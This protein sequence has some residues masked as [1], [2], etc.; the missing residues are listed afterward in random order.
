MLPRLDRQ[1]L[2]ARGSAPAPAP[3]GE[4]V[5]LEKDEAETLNEEG[6]DPITFEPFSKKCDKDD[7]KDEVDPCEPAFRVWIADELGKK[8]RHSKVYLAR[9]MWQWVGVEEKRVDPITKQLFWRQDWMELRDKYNPDKKMP[10]WVFNLPVRE[11]PLPPYDKRYIPSEDGENVT[12]YRAKKGKRLLRRESTDGSNG[13]GTLRNY[14]EYEGAKGKEAIRRSAV[15]FDDGTLKSKQWWE[16]AK[17]KEYAVKREVYHSRDSYTIHYAAGTTLFE[18]RVVRKKWVSGREVRYEGEHGKERQVSKSARV[19][20]GTGYPN[21]HHRSKDLPGFHYTLDDTYERTYTGDQGSEAIVRI[22][23]ANRNGPRATM[24]FK[25]RK[26]AL[27]PL[28]ENSTLFMVKYESLGYDTAK[29]MYQT[30]DVAEYVG[31]YPNEALSR[32][33]RA[34]GFIELYSGPANKELNVFA[35]RKEV[36]DSSV[37][38]KD[39]PDE[40][41]YMEGPVLILNQVDAVEVSDDEGEEEDDDGVDPW[42][43]DEGEEMEEV[44]E[45]SEHSSEEETE[46]EEEQTE[47]EREQWRLAAIEARERAA[48]EREER[49]QQWRQRTAAL[50]ARAERWEARARERASAP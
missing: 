24:L 7:D 32:V 36:A 49:E 13:T 4:F 1:R 25:P 9:S 45:P 21:V 26:D 33:T 39:Y 18:D 43:E 5:E 37:I 14:L 11:E 8:G 27:N 40:G 44:S 15:F 3:T 28:T 29:R 34:N 50:L 6:G 48:R 17:G 22:R 31:E 23:F 19:D 16:G 42:D 38:F 10:N 2:Y 35:M 47:E 12:E 46:S 20:E 30:G 41:M